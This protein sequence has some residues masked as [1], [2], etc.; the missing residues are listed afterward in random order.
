MYQDYAFG[1]SQ[2]QSWEAAMTR[3]GA[4]LTVKIAMPLNETNVTPYVSKVPMDGSIDGLLPAMAG[5]DEVR[6]LAVLRQFGLTRSLPLAGAGTVLK[7]YFGGRYPEELDGVIHIKPQTADALSGNTLDEAYHKSFQNLA[8][9]EAES[10]IVGLVGG[11][12][13]ATVGDQSYDA[14]TSVTALKQAMIA[15]NFGG[16]RDNEKLIAALETL[17]APQSADFPTGPMIMSKTNHQG[18]MKMYVFKVN[19]QHDEVLQTISPDQLPAL[20]GCT[21]S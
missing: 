1:Q 12:S 19:G 17:N 6:V 9:S 2:L 21:V 18:R 3:L 8:N 11:P 15:A 5:T 13:S 10:S 4:V 20:E 16:R 7:E 14:F